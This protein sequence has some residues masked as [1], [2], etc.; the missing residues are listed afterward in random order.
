MV[1]QRAHRPLMNSE[2]RI[3][4]SLMDYIFRRVAA[5]GLE[6]STVSTVRAPEH[7]NL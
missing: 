4:T 2:R 1:P 5:A 7:Q 6:E 3:A